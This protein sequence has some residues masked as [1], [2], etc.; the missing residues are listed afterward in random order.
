MSYI[1]EEYVE[2]QSQKGPVITHKDFFEV[3]AGTQPW[4]ETAEDSAKAFKASKQ[5]ADAKQKAEV[6]AAKAE[7]KAAK[8]KA[9]EL[10]E[11]PMTPENLQEVADAL[12]RA[13]AKA[14]K[15]NGKKRKAEDISE[16][17]VEAVPENPTEHEVEEAAK[18]HLKCK[19]VLLTWNVVNRYNSNQFLEKLQ[20]LSVF[21]N[22]L[23][24]TICAEHEG[25]YHL[26]AYLE[27]KKQVDHATQNWCVDTVHPNARPN[28]TKGSGF[29]TACKRGHFYVANKYKKSFV[30]HVMNY[31]PAGEESGAS[32]SVKGQ[33]VIDQWSQNKL[34]D[35]VDCAGHYRCLTPS[36]KMMF[37][38]SENVLVSEERLR[39]HVE[40]DAILA[41]E[42]RPFKTYPEITKWLEHHSVPRR[43]YH[44]L[45][46]WGDSELGK[47]QLALSLCKAPFH[48]KNAIAWKGD[49]VQ[50]A[51]N[52]SKHDGIVFDDIKNMCEYVEENKI[53]FEAKG[54]TQ[55]GSSKTNIYQEDIDSRGKKIIVCTNSPVPGGWSWIHHN[56]VFLHIDRPTWTEFLEI[57]DGDP[58]QGGEAPP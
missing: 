45:W 24:Y 29:T 12:E 48:H 6:K 3:P 16:G 19:A 9:K 49:K 30:S 13:K 4:Q 2:Q 35:P 43:R 23:R 42:D 39:Y 56:A 21:E 37:Q 14:A 33:W 36:M 34:R 1:F 7:A 20:E 31:F 22:V 32:Y 10:E 26:H 52:P 11:F 28:T 15:K 27:F 54:V 8:Q 50:G 25:H 5:K 57:E 17:N 47:T 44:F 53:M 58:S 41:A 18:H 40:M 51:Y 46:L 38:M 55:V